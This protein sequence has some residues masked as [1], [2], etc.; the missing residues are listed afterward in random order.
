[1][2]A[3]SLA[4]GRLYRRHQCVERRRLSLASCE[5][6]I[7][8]GNSSNQVLAFRAV[9]DRMT[10]SPVVSSPRVV[11]YVQHSYVQQNSSPESSANSI[12]DRSIAVGVSV[13]S[14]VDRSIAVAARKVAGLYQTGRPAGA[15]LLGSQSI[16]TRPVASLR[17]QVEASTSPFS[18]VSIPSAKGGRSVSR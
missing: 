8:Q 3:L 1:L 11:S 2:A 9:S 10:N 18:T 15:V 4:C 17:V 16:S 13:R 12:V 6:G 14:I 5:G 7:L